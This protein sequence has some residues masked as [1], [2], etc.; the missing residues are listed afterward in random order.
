MLVGL[1]IQVEA[2]DSGFA[3]VWSLGLQGFG[4]VGL[5][6]TIFGGPHTLLL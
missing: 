1:R 6:R 5:S 4:V 2:T 3:M